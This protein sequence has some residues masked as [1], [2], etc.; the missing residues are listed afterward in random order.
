MPAASPGD[1]TKAFEEISQL[2]LEESAAFEFEGLFKIAADPC[3]LLTSL[4]DVQLDGPDATTVSNF[5]ESMDKFQGWV[6]ATLSNYDADIS[7]IKEYAARN[8]SLSIEELSKLHLGCPWSSFEIRNLGGWE[9][10]FKIC[11]SCMRNVIDWL[12]LIALVLSLVL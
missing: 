6:S 5:E 10:F 12:G 8:E 1:I 9:F 3:A 4:K 11:W 7:H 2:T